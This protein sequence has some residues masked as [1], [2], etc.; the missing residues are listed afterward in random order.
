MA[1][2]SYCQNLLLFCLDKPAANLPSWHRTNW[3]WSNGFHVQ[4]WITSCDSAWTNQQLLCTSNIKANSDNLQQKGMQVQLRIGSLNKLTGE[5]SFSPTAAIKSKNQS[6]INVEH[7]GFL[8]NKVQI[9]NQN[10]INLSYEKWGFICHSSFQW[11]LI[12]VARLYLLLYDREIK[13]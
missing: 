5:S 12:K 10:E 1:K 11:K 7:S 9:C 3:I 6:K 2:L 4:S 8:K 13:H